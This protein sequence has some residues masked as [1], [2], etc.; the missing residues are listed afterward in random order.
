MMMMMVMLII[1]KKTAFKT[2]KRIQAIKYECVCMFIDINE[3]QSGLC[4]NCGSWCI[5]E[6][7]RYT[8]NCNVM[9]T[10]LHC[11]TAV[12]NTTCRLSI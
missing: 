12:D 11:E 6:I 4:Q 8:C 5:D 2:T 10:G 7:N 9:Y 3:C 1:Y